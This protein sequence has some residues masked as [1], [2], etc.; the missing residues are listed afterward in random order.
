MHGPGA[1]ALG[2]GDAKD[3]QKHSDDSVIDSLRTLIER[4]EELDRVRGALEALLA[5]NNV[6]AVAFDE[7]LKIKS[8]NLPMAGDR[9]DLADLLPYL[10]DPLLARIRESIADGSLAPG[11]ALADLGGE[12]DL[13]CSLYRDEGDP[14]LYILQLGALPQERP[15][16]AEPEE[17]W[18]QTSDR[19]AEVQRLLA[20]LDGIRRLDPT[21]NDESLKREIRE[22]RLPELRKLRGRVVDPVLALCLA[23]IE[24]NLADILA[25]EPQDMPDSIYSRLTPSEIQIADFIRMGK[26]TKDIADALDIAAKTVENHRNNLREKL[27]LRNMGV[28]LRSYLMHLGRDKGAER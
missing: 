12:R 7:S 3:M 27:G 8:H 26:S 9:S 1:A 19:L 21:V 22:V 23:I 14:P 5:R 25:P 10:G 18:D 20:A 28:N 17:V 24:K 15:S 16:S 2:E 11:E 4:D 13:R 6:F